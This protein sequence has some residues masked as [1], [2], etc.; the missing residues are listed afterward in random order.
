MAEK[1]KILLIVDDYLPHSI[2]VA[3][4]MMHELALE[5]QSNGHEVSVVTPDHRISER[6]LNRNIDGI[7]VYYFKSGKIKNVNLV[8]R[9][10]N[11]LLLSYQAWHSLKHILKNDKYDY[12]VYYSPTIFFGPLAGKLKKLYNCRTFLILRDLFP[13]WVIDNGTI[14]RYSPITFY[15][16][17]FEKLNYRNADTIAL[18]SPKNLEWFNCNYNSKIFEKALLLYNWAENNRIEPDYTFREK[19]SLEDKVIFFYGGNIGR[20]QDMGN[21]MRLAEKMKDEKNAAFVILG[22]GDE[23]DLVKRTI[24]DKNLKNTLYLPPVDQESFKKIL[25]ESDIGLFSLAADHNTHNFPG[26]LLGYM[27]QNIPIL[28]SVNKGNDLQQTIENH[29]AGFVSINGEDELF[30]QNAVKL[31]KDSSLRLKTGNNAS[32]MLEEL[33]SVEAAAEKILQRHRDIKN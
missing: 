7:N 4:K 17:L 30:Y 14:S 29:E 1:M 13:R 11:E 20:A 18:Q 15:F 28:G 24:K 12:I 22:E 16:K 33:F 27:V 23:V 5:L 9:A 26:K 19:Y 10:I 8:K 2:K 21:L 32:K 3:A 25:A 6:F 31:L